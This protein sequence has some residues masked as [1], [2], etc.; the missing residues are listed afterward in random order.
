[1]CTPGEDYT[2]MFQQDGATSRTSKVTQDH[3]DEEVPEFIKK[4]ERPQSP[5]CKP[6]DYHVHVGLTLREG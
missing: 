4:N 5:V 3:L 2:Y 1:M 6:M